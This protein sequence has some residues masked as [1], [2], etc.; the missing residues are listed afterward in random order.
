MVRSQPSPDR[1]AGHPRQSERPVIV[2]SQKQRTFLMRGMG[3]FAAVL[4]VMLAVGTFMDYQIAQ[5]IYT[6]D[7]PLV[8]FLSTLGLLPMFYP[9]CFLLGVLVQRSA[10]SRKPLVLRIVGAAVCVL[11]AALFGALITRSVLSIRDGFGGLVGAELSA[12]VRMGIG[13]VVGVVLCALGFGAGKKNDAKDLARRVLV[14]TAVLVVSYLAV[15]VVKNFMARPRPRVV[16]AG[17]DGITFSPWYQKPSGA[18]GLMAAFNLERDA[19]KSFPSGH[20]VQAAALLAAFYG[21]SLVYPGLRQKLGIALV[22]EIIFALVVMSC[23]MIL[24]AHFLS[25]VSTGALVSVIAF[26]I[27][28]VLEGRRGE[29]E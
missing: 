14:A 15:E 1:E 5:A 20:S 25:D 19:F 22:A 7:N 10:A 17:Y 9:V 6:P 4:V 24:G 16:L 29:R 3:I 21:L 2:V 27:L 28:M 11:L 18:E 23:R 8:I 13:V 26:F 12:E